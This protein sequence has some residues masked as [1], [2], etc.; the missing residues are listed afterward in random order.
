MKIFN[1]TIGDIFSDNSFNK[2][3]TRILNCIKWECSIKY[4]NKT[5][6][7]GLTTFDLL[8]LVKKYTYF[9]FHWLYFSNVN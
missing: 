8:K 2:F 1:T 5:W 7:P 3:S 4:Q 9:V 6:S